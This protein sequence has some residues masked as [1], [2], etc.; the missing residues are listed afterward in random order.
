MRANLASG[1]PLAGEGWGEGKPLSAT[2]L[3]YT[4]TRSMNA[5]SAFHAAPGF[6]TSARC[7]PSMSAI[8]T[9][10][11]SRRI[12]SARS[13][14]ITPS[15]RR[16]QVKDRYR[17]GGERLA[18]V[19][20]QCSA[21]AARERLDACV[22]V[23]L[24]EQPSH[25]GG[26]VAAKQCLRA[27]RRRIEAEQRWRHEA[28]HPARQVRHGR[29]HERRRQDHAAQSGRYRRGYEQRERPRE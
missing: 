19:D 10:G 13:P 3:R 20:R 27:R 24:C 23:R 22:R 4:P 16:A 9:D 14:R 17:A 25:L 29:L 21:G 7:G 15:L 5:P 2:S 11:R 12:S 28:V 18:R 1:G 6:V 26:A 8:S